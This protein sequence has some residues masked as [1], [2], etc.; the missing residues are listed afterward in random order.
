M[1][2]PL[3]MNTSCFKQKIQYLLDPSLYREIFLDP[4]PRNFGEANEDTKTPFQKCC[5][6]YA[7][8]ITENIQTRPMANHEFNKVTRILHCLAPLQVT[9]AL[10][11]HTHT[12]K[13]PAHR[14]FTTLRYSS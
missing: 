5:T 1:N 13:H 4:T 14:I 12:K 7:L 8:W 10:G 9:S 2:A 3:V 11:H 6:T